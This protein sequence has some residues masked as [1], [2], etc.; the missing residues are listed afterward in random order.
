MLA[1][2]PKAKQDKSIL[3]DSNHVFKSNKSTERSNANDVKE[4][5]VGKV[6]P[7]FEREWIRKS[8]LTFLSFPLALSSLRSWGGK[9]THALDIN[10]GKNRTLGEEVYTKIKLGIRLVR[11]IKTNNVE[12]HRKY[13]NVTIY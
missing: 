12:V 2:K 7:L 4:Y 1:N 6:F 10:R 5:H 13:I 11:L 9:I 8:S 3:L